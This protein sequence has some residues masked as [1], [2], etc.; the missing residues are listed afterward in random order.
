MLL[1]P[2][3]QSYHSLT[4]TAHQLPDFCPSDMQMAAVRQQ[5]PLLRS[6]FSRHFASRLHRHQLNE[7]SLNGFIMRPHRAK[8][9]DWLLETLV[10]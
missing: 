9:S 8:I 4:Y 10:A 5:Y 3:R 7:F 6:L 2:F 1:V